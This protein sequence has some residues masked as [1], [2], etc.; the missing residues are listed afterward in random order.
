MSKVI[1]EAYSML[2]RGEGEPLSWEIQGSNDKISW[3]TIDSKTL[4]NLEI[5]TTR[6]YNSFPRSKEYQYIQIIQKDRNK[7]GN[8]R[9][10]LSRFELF[11]VLVQKKK[12]N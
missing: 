5:K 2:T 1:V 12:F 4:L 6:T 7:R 3:E 8:L 10:N 11:G 9:L